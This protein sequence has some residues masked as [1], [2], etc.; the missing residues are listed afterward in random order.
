MEK[1]QRIIEKDEKIKEA[2]ELAS[3]VDMNKL[4]RGISTLMHSYGNLA[5]TMGNVQ[6]EQEGALEAIFYLGENLPMFV[7]KLLEKTSPEVFGKIMKVMFRMLSLSSKIGDMMHLPPEEKIS[8][9]EEL[10]EFA[11]ELVELTE[12]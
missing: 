9:G 5:T 10:E 7:D 8:L 12:E 2:L 1:E 6:L 4:M 3:K 11:K